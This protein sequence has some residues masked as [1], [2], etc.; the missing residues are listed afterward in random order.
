MGMDRKLSESVKSKL[1]DSH[2]YLCGV[3]HSDFDSAITTGFSSASKEDQLIRSALFGAHTDLTRAVLS[4]CI[5][6]TNTM[7]NTLMI[8]FNKI[9]GFSPDIGD[10]HWK[11]TVSL[12]VAINAIWLADFSKPPSVQD[13]LRYLQ[14]EK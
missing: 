9:H 4:E 13:A 12:Q 8:A 5:T 2:K 14:S 3:V 6:F 1:K 11:D 7:L 10:H